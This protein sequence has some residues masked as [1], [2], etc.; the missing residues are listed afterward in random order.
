V[1]L[2]GS[3][4]ETLT[5]LKDDTVVPLENSE[6]RVT[7]AEITHL[8]E[9]GD[10]VGSPMIYEVNVTTND[11]QLGNISLQDPNGTK[12][13]NG[14][15][16]GRSEGVIE[17]ETKDNV[18]DSGDNTA[19]TDGYV[20]T[21]KFNIIIEDNLDG[22]TSVVYSA[23]NE[24]E[25]GNLDGD[26]LKT[27][28]YKQYDIDASA[29]GSVTTE[30]VLAVAERVPG[31]GVDKLPWDTGDEVTPRAD[32]DN[33]GEV[34]SS[35]LATIVGEWNQADFVEEV[36]AT[37][38]GETAP[39]IGVGNLS[40]LNVT[41][42]DQRRGDTPFDADAS[43]EGGNVT[44]K[45]IDDGGD[46]VTVENLSVGDTLRVTEGN[47]SFGDVQF[48]N[49][50]SGDTVD[51]TLAVTNNIDDPDPEGTK[52]TITVELNDPSG[53]LD[54]ELNTTSTT[55]EADLV[56]ALNTSYTVE[57]AFA[58]NVSTINVSV[59]DGGDGSLNLSGAEG[60]AT[61]DLENG[62]IEIGGE[63]QDIEDGNVSTIGSSPVE[64]IGIKISEQDIEAGEKI[65][66]NTIS[67]VVQ[68]DDGEND[69]ANITIELKNE[70]NDVIGNTNATDQVSYNTSSP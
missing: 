65:I 15:F 61:K 67:D 57:N 49:A 7:E 51:I 18:F 45:N 59:S 16:N 27:T 22:N 60:N 1:T 35:N 62:T 42:F 5:A 46:D 52:E 39:T 69:S 11:G 12:I 37:V 14:S 66:L 23:T 30:D 54:A 4:T 24:A 55:G 17:L 50:V 40:D 6:T 20:E 8:T 70:A 33:T 28:I 25:N 32:L 3:D 34:T 41:V 10:M 38:D 31:D 64:G 13:A 19:E 56:T 63:T 36:N 9:G 43:T 2:T 58:L 29:Q 53:S 44:V 26:I 21:N 47:A 68:V 48:G